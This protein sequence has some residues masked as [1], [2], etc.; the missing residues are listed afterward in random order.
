MK[1]ACIFD[2]TS[3]FY[4]EICP[5][6][7][8]PSNETIFLSSTIKV[9]QFSFFVCFYKIETK[10]LINKK[11]LLKTSFLLLKATSKMKKCKITMMMQIRWLL[12]RR[13]AP[14]ARLT[15]MLSSRLQSIAPQSRERLPCLKGSQKKMTF[16]LRTL[17]WDS[18]N[19]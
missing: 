5:K 10:I 6:L 3:I 19:F 15:L 9:R 12:Y 2:N 13:W 1:S 14:L 7:E 8:R 16:R 11:L 4:F 18:F 17:V